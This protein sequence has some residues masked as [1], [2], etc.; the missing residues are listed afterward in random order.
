VAELITR[1]LR[2]NMRRS[3]RLGMDEAIELT[4]V[5]P[6]DAGMHAL[7]DVTPFE[8]IDG[9]EAYPGRQPRTDQHSER[10]GVLHHRQGGSESDASF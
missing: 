7:W 8:T 1:K 5:A 4:A 6:T 9:Y 10:W 3:Y 2:A